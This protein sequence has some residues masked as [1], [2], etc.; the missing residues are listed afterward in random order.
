[1]GIGSDNIWHYTI[2][3]N[4]I[5]SI[6]PPDIFYTLNICGPIYSLTQHTVINF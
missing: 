5:S 6:Q 4:N 1:M 2:K 3:D